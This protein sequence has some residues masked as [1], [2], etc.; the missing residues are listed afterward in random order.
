MHRPLRVPLY[1]RVWNLIKGI[2]F[3]N[4][5]YWEKA[6]DGLNMPTLTREER[7]RSRPKPDPE[8]VKPREKPRV[9]KDGFQGAQISNSD[10]E[11]LASEYFVSGTESL[12]EALPVPLPTRTTGD[13]HPAVPEGHELKKR[14]KYKR[15][16]TG[17][18]YNKHSIWRRVFGRS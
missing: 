11:L 18:A 4:T 6:S 9:R 15:R 17:S 1:L 8:I 5:V 16:R 2:L 13:E 3:Y 12:P 14:R 7:E 10:A